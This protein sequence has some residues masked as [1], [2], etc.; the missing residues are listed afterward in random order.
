[1]QGWIETYLSADQPLFYP[2]VGLSLLL[3]G[4]GFPISADL[5]LLTVGYLAYQG[6]ADY[7]IL[8]PL[9]IV[10]ILLSDTGMFAIGS[11]VGKRAVGIWPFRK[12]FTPARLAAAEQ[13]FLKQGYRIVFLARFMPGIRTVF[14]F[15]SGLLNLRYWKFLIHDLAGALIVVPGTILSVKWVAGNLDLIREKMAKAQWF[16]LAAVAIAFVVYFSSRSRR[17]RGVVDAIVVDSTGSS[18]TRSGRTS[19]PE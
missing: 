5:V 18:E 16:V 11:K 10:A 13:S 17:R 19:L 1:M 6:H 9:C 14:M 4:L 7:A 2:M 8:I 3:A 12:A 15:S